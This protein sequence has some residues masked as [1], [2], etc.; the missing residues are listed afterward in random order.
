MG[1]IYI[2]D[3][4]SYYLEEY[5]L[6]YKR[7]DLYKVLISDP[8][9]PSMASISCTM[10]Y[11][12]ITSAAYKIS[13]RVSIQSIEGAIVHTSILRGHFFILKKIGKECVLLYDGHNVKLALDDFQKVWDGV[14]LIPQKPQN[15][16]EET[17]RVFPNFGAILLAIIFFVTLAASLPNSATQLILNDFIGA[18]LC[19]KLMSKMH[20]LPYKDSFCKIGNKIDCEYV[21]SKQPLRNYIRLG[22]EEVG[23]MYFI[24]DIL[25]C[26]FDR[27]NYASAFIVTFIGTI[28][29]LF[30]LTFQIIKIKKYCIY[31]I[32]I[33]F[34]ILFKLIEFKFIP[35]SD[36][37]IDQ[38][39]GSIICA[40]ASYL[41]YKQIKSN[42]KLQGH[43]I[44]VETKFLK[45]K[46][47]NLIY[48]ILSSRTCKEHFPPIKG[49][50]F[51]NK[52]GDCHFDMIVS[53]E[54][55]YCRNAIDQILMLLTQNPNK[56]HL[57]IVLVSKLYLDIGEDTLI[58]TSK[59]ELAIYELYNMGM[60]STS[61]LR[62]SNILF[63]KKNIIS[64][65]TLLQ[66]KK[67]IS[68]V[69]Q[70]KFE[71]LPVI[72]VNGREKPKEYDI[73]DYQYLYFGKQ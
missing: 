28:F 37:S 58:T 64:P 57:N 65:N 36:F 35:I 61:I 21:A 55:E 10:A 19:Y 56:F 72:Y 8:S 23:L 6:S 31:C 45:L 51:G 30:L 71:G 40:I 24:W 4:I 11:Y 69:K 33:Y 22:L 49:L 38:F 9:Y 62:D 42:M 14:V 67:I 29:C 32:S 39:V 1:N 68:E 70:S 25:L 44:D 54:C 34:I 26:L 15:K 3:I 5:K 60:K 18:F 59:K 43:S 47:D 66:Y 50:E 20:Y 13:D 2:L 27:Q 12:G 41:V 16:T 53:L 46:R 48:N 63:K 73:T 52:K 17:Q 7:H